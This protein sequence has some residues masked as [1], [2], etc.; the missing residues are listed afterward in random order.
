MVPSNCPAM[1]CN[2]LTTCKLSQI[3]IT[4]NNVSESIVRLLLLIRMLNIIIHP[5]TKYMYMGAM[6]RIHAFGRSIGRH[7]LPLID[8][9]PSWAYCYPVL[10]R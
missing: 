4:S 8:T 1:L 9:K 2:H 6:Y 5:D 7:F 10:V 3:D